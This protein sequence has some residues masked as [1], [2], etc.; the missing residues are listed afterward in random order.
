M[1]VSRHVVVWLVWA[2]VSSVVAFL[3]ALARDRRRAMKDRDAPARDVY[4]CIDDDGS[5]REL[6]P[7]EAVYLSTEFMFGDGGAP[8]IKGHYRQRAPGGHLGGFLARRDLPRG[9]VVRPAGPGDR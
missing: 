2:V 7:D 1:S 5:A 6:T 4:V 9:T 8:Y 3:I